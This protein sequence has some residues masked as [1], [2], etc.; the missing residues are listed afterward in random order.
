MPEMTKDEEVEAALLKLLDLLE[1]NKPNDRSE[2][3][4]LWAIIR[5]DAQKLLAFWF[6]M[7]M[8]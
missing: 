4:R 5:T 6:Y 2:K 3:D 7:E 1:K 8:Q